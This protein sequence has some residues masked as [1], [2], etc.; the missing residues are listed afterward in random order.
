MAGHSKWA[1][2]KRH[3]AKQDADA[4]LKKFK[5]GS[6]VVYQ[7]PIKDNKGNEVI[8]AGKSY[9]QTDIW[10]ESMGWLVEG[11]VGSA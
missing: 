10:L 4:V 6:M 9:Q 8:P 3:K 1:N 5:E 11:V 2:I 7:G